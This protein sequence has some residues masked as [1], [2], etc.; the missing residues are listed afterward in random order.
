MG[1]KKKRR[2]KNSQMKEIVGRLFR[3]KAAI[4]G[5]MILLVLVVCAVFAD[6]LAPYDYAA[7]DLKNRFVAPCFA[8]PFGTDNL[9][10]DILSRIIYGSRISLTVGLASVSLAAMIGI[11]LG[12]IAGFYGGKSDNII[13][14]AM[15]VLLAIPSLLLAI[16]I[17]ATLGNGIPNLILAI[18]F[19]AAPTYARIVRASILSLKEQ[20]FIEAARSVGASD[21]RIIFHHILPNCLA[22]IIVQM[23]L[24]VASAILSTAS[25]SFIGLG[26]APP[27]PE[28]GSMLSAGR[29]Y[30][31]DAWHIVTF[32]GAAIMITIFGLNL[33]GD[34][35]RDALDPK[36]KN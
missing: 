21:F 31:R 28:W 9:G 29:Q 7:Q 18:G 15:D 27:T 24:G 4:V 1:G 8:H 13:M 11:F 5:L 35:L 2:R 12:S 26:I 34:G 14:R 30:I 32:P 3:N 25:L 20:E 22:P 17:A 19:G 23:T 33:F 6:L 36:L 16:S 10:R